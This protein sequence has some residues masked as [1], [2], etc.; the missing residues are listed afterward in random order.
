MIIPAESRSEIGWWLANV[1][2]E[3]GKL[4]REDPRSHSLHTDSSMKGWGAFLDKTSC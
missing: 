3:N 4:I 1:N 2:S